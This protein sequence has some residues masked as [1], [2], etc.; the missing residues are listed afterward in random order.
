M[1]ADGEDLRAPMTIDSHVHFWRYDRGRDGW[2]TDSM[3]ML[4]RDL[5]ERG[6]WLRPFG[7]L[8]Y[9]MP[10]YIISRGELGRI[11]ATL[12]ELLGTL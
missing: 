8:V 7:K 6:I 4:Q 9:L 5:V 11:T 10:P 12:R 1:D 3:A 2:I